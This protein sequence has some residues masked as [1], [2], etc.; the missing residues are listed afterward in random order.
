VARAG[1]SP[2]APD[3]LRA[4]SPLAARLRMREG[5]EQVRTFE[6]VDSLRV[7]HSAE[8]RFTRRVNVAGRDCWLF[9]RLWKS[10]ATTDTSFYCVLLDA[11]TLVM[12][13]EWTHASSDSGE[14][15]LRDGT[16][17]GWHVARG[18]SAESLRVAIA[19]GSVPASVVSSVVS[20]LPLEAGYVVRIPTFNM[21]AHGAQQWVE[22]RVVGEAALDVAG[23]HRRCWRV[24]S[25]ALRAWKVEQEFWVDRSAHRLVLT[26]TRDPR[27]RRTRREEVQ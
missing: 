11:R 17:A 27:T 24:A 25:D 2:A 21:W 19:P 4:G 12:V 1:D 3:T 14:A 9:S 7:P 13:K 10:A 23:H 22:L 16:L 5:I 26:L 6:V 15:V 8:T 20:A 18:D